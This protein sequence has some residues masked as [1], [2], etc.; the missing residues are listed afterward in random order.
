MIKKS[1]VEKKDFSTEL[2]TKVLKNAIAS[3]GPRRYL[4][5]GFPRNK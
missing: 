4:I 1:I 5:D 3:L 2:V